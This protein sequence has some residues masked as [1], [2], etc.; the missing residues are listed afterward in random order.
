MRFDRSVWVM[1]AAVAA[2]I[3]LVVG[4]IVFLG[5]FFYYA[6]ALPSPD[7]VVRRDGFSTKIYDRNGK[8]LYDVYSGEKRTPVTITQVPLYLQQATVAIEDKSFYKNQGFDP[9]TP[10]R[11]IWNVITKGR[12]VGGSGLTQQLVKNVLLTPEQTPI[13]KLK[14]FILAIQIDRKYTKDQILQMYLNEAPYGGPIWGVQAA[15]ESLFG[16]SV[17]DLTLAESAI[18]A[19][20]PQSPSSY[21]PYN[22]N[23]YIGRANDVLRR[24]REDGYINKTQEADADA[25]VKLVTFASESGSIKAPHFVFYIKSLLEQKYGQKIVEQGGLKVTTTLDLDIQQNA[26]TVVKEE[27][28]KVK[29]LNITNGAAMVMDPKTGQILAMVGSRGWSDPDYDGKF[30]VTTASRQPGSSIKPI[31]YLAGLRKGYTASTM[32]MDVPTS[33]PGGDKP[34]Y[35]PVNYDGKFRG[36]ISMRDALGN[37]INVPAVKMLSLVG[38]KDTL[39][40]AYTMG[41]STLEPTTANLNRLGLSMAL[42]GGEVKL[43][44]MAAAYD[45]FANGGK[46]TEP[47]GILEVKDSNDKVLEK[48]QPI[49]LT[50][51]IDPG[52]AFIISSMLSDPAARLITFGPNSALNIANRTVAVK[53]GTTNDKRDNWAIGWTPSVL[54]GVWVGNNN[55]SAMKQV[56]SGISGASPIWRRIMLTALNKLPNEGFTKPDNV[57]SMDVDKVSGYKAHDNFDARQEY[58]I[59]G[60]QPDGTDPIHKMVRSCDGSMKEYFFFKES[61]PFA[62][63]GVNKWQEGIDTWL[64]DQSEPRYHPP[65]DGGTSCNNTIWLTVKEPSDKA[66]INSNDVKIAVDISS[67]KPIAKTE[68]SVDGTLKD[69]VTSSPWETTINMT[70]GSHQIDIRSL[71]GDGNEG[72]RRI[73]VGVNQDYVSP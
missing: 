48:W 23:L 27:I 31:V 40:L 39:Q 33:F 9:L 24:M 60:T 12:I 51:V 11:I 22:G 49:S 19:G 64:K 66:R 29:Y 72:S 50:Q 4:I 36:P 25:Q 61:D 62:I 65:A 55:N 13:R 34:S 47:V 3:L 1:R 45:A 14:E 68:F 38:V 67:S 8:L 57:V 71:D 30:N 37:S 15:A 42:G 70:N 53:T 28:D 44:D 5:L 32:F 20:L 73:F 69:T 10:L 59:N 58:F 7:N 21:S 52:E 26:E 63:N 46:K 54:V 2:V 18:L 56:S 17:S 6:R 35:D 43:L 41:L 16:K